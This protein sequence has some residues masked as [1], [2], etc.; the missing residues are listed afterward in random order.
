[1]SSAFAILLSK[2]GKKVVIIDLDLG[3]SN[4]HTIFGMAQPQL[5]LDDFISKKV[6]NINDVRLKTPLDNLHLISGVGGCLGYANPKYVQKVKLISK[7]R[8]ID[9]DYVIMDIGAG[10]S[11]NELDFFLAADRQILITCPEPSSIQD[12]F[13]FIKTALYRKLR[14]SF[15]RH[16]D[17]VSILDKS[18]QS[19]YSSEMNMLLPQ[20]FQLGPEYIEKFG[21]ILKNYAP[22]LVVN[23][24]ME[25]DEAKEGF[26]AVTAARKLLNIELSYLGFVYFDLDVRKSTKALTPF[27]LNNP[28]SSASTCIMSILCDRLLKLSQVES[29]ETKSRLL[30]SI[31]SAPYQTSAQKGYYNDLPLYPAGYLQNQPP[32]SSPAT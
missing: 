29:R 12:G 2:M 26:S 19:G 32:N 6:K 4:M 25:K 16:P 27:I 31:S 28:E 21:Q 22:S 24:V 11:F 1:M 23:M 5:T 8:N 7:L 10:S 18:R 30:R 17:V 15:R 13:N 14:H 3:G 20:I 9:A